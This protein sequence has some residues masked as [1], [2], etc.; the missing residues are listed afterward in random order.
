MLFVIH[1]NMALILSISAGKGC[2]RSLMSLLKSSW[3]LMEVT[4]LS[5]REKSR[6]VNSCCA[7]ECICSESKSSNKAALDFKG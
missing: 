5:T 1:L 2:V 4:K 3:Y 7:A 6:E